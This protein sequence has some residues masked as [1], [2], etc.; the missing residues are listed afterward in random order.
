[1]AKAT[2]T[3]SSRVY[4]PATRT[5]ILP[6]L[7]A[8]DAGVKIILTREAW[9]DTGSEIVT[10]SIEGTNDAWATSF[11]L[12]VFGYVG[13]VMLNPRT[14]LPVLTVEPTAY[15][16]ETTI[17]GVAVPQRPQEVRLVITNTVTLTTAIT[18][19]GV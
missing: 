11:N 10:G 5:V 7:T 4:T 9:L 18:L 17:D 12:T 14:G 16:P 19:T 15:W 6:N 3:V 8:D 1:M 2:I 13:G